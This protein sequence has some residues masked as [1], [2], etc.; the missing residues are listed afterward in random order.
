MGRR[1]TRRHGFTVHDSTFE[2]FNEG[3]AVYRFFELFDLP[4]V[5][6]AKKIF[7]LARRKENPP[8]AAAEADFRREDAVRAVVESAS[9][10]FLA[11]GTRRKFFRTAEAMRSLHV[12]G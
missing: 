8:D 12:D 10:E 4:N 11:A 7:E 1:A 5:P 3:D 2:Q 9:A 6:N